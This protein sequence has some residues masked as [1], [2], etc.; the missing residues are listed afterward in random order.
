MDRRDK[1]LD[2]SQQRPAKVG[3]GCQPSLRRASN[4]VLELPWR[5]EEPTPVRNGF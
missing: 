5:P 4:H 2:T 3:D 1:E